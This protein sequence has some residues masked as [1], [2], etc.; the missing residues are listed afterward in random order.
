MVFNRAVIIK[1]LIVLVIIIISFFSSI[2]LFSNSINKKLT[3]NLNRNIKVDWGDENP[4]F[5]KKKLF[6]DILKRSLFWE[7]LKIIFPNKQTKHIMNSLSEISSDSCKLKI[8]LSLKLRILV[9]CNK[10]SVNYAEN[11]W[12]KDGDLKIS[13]TFFFERRVFDDFF[14]KQGTFN[15]LFDIEN[16]VINKNNLG[17]YKVEYFFID[18]KTFKLVIDEKEIIISKKDEG[19]IIDSSDGAYFFLN[20]NFFFNTRNKI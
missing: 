14:D 15:I 8:S 6:V 12:V 4:K 5:E 11:N 7:E 2:I 13:R 17:H 1:L 9:K 20:E 18:D 19:M 10:V 16:L 3:D